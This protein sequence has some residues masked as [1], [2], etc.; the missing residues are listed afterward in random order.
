MN[1]KD[2]QVK[3][4]SSYSPL[5]QSLLKKPLDTYYRNIASVPSMKHILNSFYE[6]SA[7]DQ[8][9]LNIGAVC[10]LN[11]CRINEILSLEW[12]Q[13]LPSGLAFI[14]A[15]KGS[16]SKMVYLGIT[17]QD[18]EEMFPFNPRTLIYH[19]SY[20]EVYKCLVKYNCFT[21]EQGHL[22]RSVTHSGRYTLAERVR[23]VLGQEAAS[24]V[25]GHK[26]KTAIDNYLGK[27]DLKKERERKYRARLRVLNSIHTAK[28]PTWLQEA[29]EEGV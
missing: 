17:P 24:Q 3:L 4:N 29:L 10:K 19:A 21:Y 12:C 11:G 1:I 23:G 25:L 18:R 15:S 5:K 26:S 27:V 6:L 8:Y 20:I 9:L 16:N 7:R 28:I 2:I 13:T 14:K 22:N